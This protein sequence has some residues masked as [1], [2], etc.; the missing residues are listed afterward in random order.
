MFRSDCS[1]FFRES[2]HCWSQNLPNE[3]Y[4]KRR[5]QM[6]PK[7]APVQVERLK[8]LGTRVAIRAGEVLVEPGERQQRLLVV[9]DGNLE[10]EHG[11]EQ[12]TVL[13]AGDFS[14]ELSTLRGVA[15]F[16]RIRAR[17][18]GTVLAIEAER[19]RELVQTD[20]ELS[21]I[22]MRAFIL[23]RMGL[24]AS[25]HAEVTLVGSRTCP[26]TLKLREFLTRNAHP[27][28]SLDL[29]ADPE[30]QALL[31]RFRVTRDEIPVLIGHCGRVFRHPSVHDIAEYLK[32]NPAL[33]LSVVHDVVV[34]GA[35]PAGLSAATYAAS[36]G[37]CVLVI[38]S[39]AF[40]G[41]AGSSSKIENYL[42]FPTGISGQALAGRAFVQAQKFGASVIVAADAARLRCDERPY[43][44]EL[45]DGRAVRTRSVVIAT[46]AQY[47]EPELENLRRF[48]GVGVYYAATHLEAKL[49]RGEEVVIVGGGN[50]AGQAAVFLAGACRHVHILVR[51][52]GLSESMSDYLIRRIEASPNITL[53]TRTQLTTLEGNGR[54]ERIA[55]R[56]P[57]GTQARDIAHVFLMTGAAPNTRWL[58]DCV[59]LDDKG[60]VCT[61]S[62]LTAQ[63]LAEAQWPLERA[64]H[65]L[66]TCIPGV[67]AIGDVRSGSVKRIATAVGEGSI[68]VQLVHRSL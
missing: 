8:A 62:Q 55:W 37:L 4:E 33:D 18:S 58:E 44:V 3:I 30:V 15:G 31:E 39:L 35:G 7:L 5:E 40:G 61:G 23:R 49:C 20:A 22:M 42:G 32:M 21:E 27:H 28:V 59:C 34:A 41:Q 65:M 26:A 52:G 38:E 1:R 45:A 10:V 13:E 24:I 50:S 2:K 64:P 14:G 68:C 17:D 51:S 54:L 63:D 36:E 11:E 47:R 29:E 16:T 56:S 9:L 66:E 46:G 60:F 25:E 43:T 67:F 57:E 19:L 53:H 48:T 6:F 12:V